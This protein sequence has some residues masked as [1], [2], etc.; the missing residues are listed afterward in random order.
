M[1]STNGTGEKAAITKKAEINNLVKLNVLSLN[2]KGEGQPINRK[3]ATTDSIKL[4]NARVN[5]EIIKKQESIKAD[6]YG[7]GISSNSVSEMAEISERSWT[8]PKGITTIDNQV[9]AEGIPVKDDIAQLD[10]SKYIKRGKK[11]DIITKK[12]ETSMD[13][14]PIGQLNNEASTSEKGEQVLGEKLR[15]RVEEIKAIV[16]VLEEEK[17]ILEEKV[18]E[19]AKVQDNI[20]SLEIDGEGTT[21]LNEE[22]KNYQNNVSEVGMKLQVEID[23]LRSAV[24][25]RPGTIIKLRNNQGAMEIEP[26]KEVVDS[27]GEIASEDEVIDTSKKYAKE[28]TSGRDFVP[29]LVE[30]V[31]ELLSSDV[32]QDEVVFTTGHVYESFKDRMMMQLKFLNDADKVYSRIKKEAIEEGLI[33]NLVKGDDGVILTIPNIEARVN[34]LSSDSEITA[35]ENLTEIT[36][37]SYN[38]QI[39]T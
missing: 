28:I 17:K 35:S 12:T 26:I 19:V 11:I 18:G 29:S 21:A 7:D 36:T 22:L 10:L 15:A 39:A 1:N 4:D 2:K 24:K 5:G 37:D 6:S 3:D 16:N 38:E 13:E 9:S 30:G 33:I 27:M 25:E 31:E 32:D 20:K 23:E 34:M 8:E 14:K